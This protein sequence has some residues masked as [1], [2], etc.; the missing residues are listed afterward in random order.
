MNFYNLG[1]ISKWLTSVLKLCEAFSHR[2]TVITMAS[3]EKN[4]AEASVWMIEMNQDLN[5]ILRL[6]EQMLIKLGK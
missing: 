2:G 1:N 4:F 3:Q 5:E 6:K